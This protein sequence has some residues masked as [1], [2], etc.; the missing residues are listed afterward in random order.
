MRAGSVFLRRRPPGVLEMMKWLQ[1]STVPPNEN[2]WALLPKC[3]FCSPLGLFPAFSVSLTPC[4]Y[5][6]PFMLIGAH[7]SLVNL[8]LSLFFPWHVN[9]QQP[10]QSLLS[11]SVHQFPHEQPTAHSHFTSFTPVP[12]V[13]MAKAWS[14]LWNL[15]AQ[16]LRTC[17]KFLLLNPSQPGCPSLLWRF[18]P[19]IAPPILCYFLI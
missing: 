18:I 6:S 10:P 1:K 9:I 7:S 15:R 8:G 3:T 11:E 4:P 2:T 14:A 17:F 19:F 5:F 12:G 16:G 13:I